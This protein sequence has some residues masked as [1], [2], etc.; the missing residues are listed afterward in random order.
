MMTYS[1]SLQDKPFLGMFLK[2]LGIALYP[3]SDAFVKHFI[4]IYSVPQATFL[5]ALVRMMPLLILVF[6]QGGFKHVF[7]PQQSKLHI[8]R[9]LI[10]V[11]STFCFMYAFSSASLTT[12]YTLGYT[13]PI[14]MLILS[15]LLLKESLKFQ[16]WITI[17]VGLITVA[18]GIHPGSDI[19]EIAALLVLSA[20]FLAALNKVLI[21]RLASTEHSLAIAI[22]PNI[23]IMLM[24]SPFLFFAGHWQPLPLFHWG[25]F[26]L[27][28]AITAIGQY[29]I[30]QALRFAQASILAPADYSSFFWVVIIDLL[31]WGKSPDKYT[32]TSAAIIMISTFFLLYKTKREE[33]IKKPIL[34]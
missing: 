21:R 26:A 24:I 28:G 19:F 25:V 10:N 2:L 13:T 3:L 29:A 12:V 17:G 22:Y 27:I 20:S 6:F 1:R 23:L 7:S 8:V 31:W 32:L 16:K 14:F 34:V 4:E 30:A 33:L 11:A 15:A 18:L 9:L 5:R